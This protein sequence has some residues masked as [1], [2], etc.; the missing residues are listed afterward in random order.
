M[1]HSCQRTIAPQ[2]NTS[3]HSTSS[4]NLTDQ[5]LKSGRAEMKSNKVCVARSSETLSQQDSAIE[6]ITSDSDSH[7]TQRD[8]NE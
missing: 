3:L 6:S 8:V 7:Q 1:L 2:T 4:P 5:S